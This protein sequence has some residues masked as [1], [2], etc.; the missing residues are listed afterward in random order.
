MVGSALALE[1]VG[2]ME[3]EPVNTPPHGVRD[4]VASW[5]A[6]GYGITPPSNMDSP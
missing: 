2:S 5:A 1:E 4:E 6:S 3:E